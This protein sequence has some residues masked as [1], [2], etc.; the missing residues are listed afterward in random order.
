MEAIRVLLLVASALFAWSMG[1]HYAGAVVG[2]AYGAGVVQLRT[3]LLIAASGALLGSVFGS[4]RVIDTYAN[5]LVSGLAELD[6][7]AALLASSLVT[8]ASTYFRLPTSTI[9]IYA[10]SLLGAALISGATIHAAGFGLVI[11]GWAIGPLLAF[12]IAIGIVRLTH[13]R[14]HDRRRFTRGVSGLVLLASC[15]SALTLGS[16]DVSNA[17]SALATT[18]LLSG[19]LLLGLYGGAFMALGALTWGRR[20][21]ERI[22]RDVVILDVPLAAT[23][24]LA[25][26]ASLSVL[27]AL[28]HNA[29]INQTIV[30]GLA[31]AGTGVD[32]RLVNWPV[33]RNIILTWLLSPALALA[34]TA[35]IALVLHIGS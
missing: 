5:G 12:A 35:L 23:A 1:S 32:R 29:S 27:N 16:N 31:G 25:Q 21:T 26:A 11:A 7:A 19:R 15:Y 22:G 14:E 33:I 3:A 17:V 2:S 9:Q 28:G 4:V 8:V 30:G 20:L 24:Q 10:F 6:V 18:D 34:A 13:R